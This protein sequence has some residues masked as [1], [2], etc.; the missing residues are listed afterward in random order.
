MDNEKDMIN[1][2]A[3]DRTVFTLDQNRFMREWCT[4][5]KPGEP[6][7]RTL[8]A[9]RTRDGEIVGFGT[10]RLFS[11]IYELRPLYAD[12]DQAAEALLVEL[13]LIYASEC[14]DKPLHIFCDAK[15]RFMVDIVHRLKLV[16]LLLHSHVR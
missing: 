3:Y 4:T 9:N 15:N 16:S 2:L 8:I 10:V 1:L 7:A 12:N 5:S 6:Y 11:S 13:A 14:G